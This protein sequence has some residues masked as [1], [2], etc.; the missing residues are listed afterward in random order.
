MYLFNHRA[1]I[2]GSPL[3]A[4][5][6][7]FALGGTRA[8]VRARAVRLHRHQRRPPHRARP[9]IRCCTPT[10]ACSRASTRS[11][12]CPRATPQSWLAWL[13]NRGL[14]RARAVAH[15]RRPACRRNGRAHAVRRRAQ[16]DRVPDRSSARLRRRPRRIARGSSISPTCGRTRRIS[17]PRRTTRCTTPRRCP[18]P[19]APRR[20][21]RRARS[22]R[23]SA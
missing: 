1:A 20:T 23:C 2:N 13:R 9:T 8:R 19:C 10:K 7:N 11:A 5:F 12:T 3:D 4:R 6:T 21:P 16:P 18:R 14:R 22:I 15:V 17:R